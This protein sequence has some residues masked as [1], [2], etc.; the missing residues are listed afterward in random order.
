L[1]DLVA[2]VDLHRV[3]RESNELVGGHPAYW[4]QKRSRDLLGA[5]ALVERTI[6]FSEED[7]RM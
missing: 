4:N 5:E 1:A 6:R 2:H 7:R 3:V